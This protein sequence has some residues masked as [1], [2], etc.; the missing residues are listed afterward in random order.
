M[1]NLT[2]LFS[3]GG[4]S[5]GGDASSLLQR[6]KDDLSKLDYNQLVKIAML[7]GWALASIYSVHSMASPKHSAQLQAALARREAPQDHMLQLK[8]D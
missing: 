7:Q 1:F 5:G 4:G 6:L 2:A 3:G 8:G